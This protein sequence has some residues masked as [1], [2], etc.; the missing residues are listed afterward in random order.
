MNEKE[1]LILLIKLK[2]DC[3]EPVPGNTLECQ[4]CL[5]SDE[6]FS[7]CEEHTKVAVPASIRYKKAI[8]IFVKLYSE[9]ELTEVLL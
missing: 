5:L 4:D 1:Q 9:E 7:Y 8:E 2:G 3:F 6:C